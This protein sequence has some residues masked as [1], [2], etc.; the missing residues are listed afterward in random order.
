[1]K[2]QK[3]RVRNLPENI[4]RSRASVHVKPTGILFLLLCIGAMIILL[5]QE[6]FIYGVAMIMLAIFALTILP[7]RILITFADDYLVLYNQQDRSICVLLYYDEIV[8]WQ[9]EVHR[10]YDRILFTLVDGSCE[11]QEMFSLCAV[12][13]NLEEH[14]PGKQKKSLRVRKESV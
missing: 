3:I 7:D 9:Y 8:N 10:T 4:T 5:L 2:S 11:S 14:L 6:L 13:K 1:M 12:K